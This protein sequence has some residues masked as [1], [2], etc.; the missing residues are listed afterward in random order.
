MALLGIPSQ[1]R[2]FE[3]RTRAITDVATMLYHQSSN[4]DA[5]VVTLIQ[6]M[7][8]EDVS[9]AL[10][11]QDYAWALMGIAATFRGVFPRDLLL[12]MGRADGL[13]APLRVLRFLTLHR[14]LQSGDDGRNLWVSETLRDYIYRLQA[15]DDLVRRHRRAALFYQTQDRPLTYAW[16]LYLAGSY[17]EAARVVLASAEDLLDALYV[18][19]LAALLMRFDA[20]QVPDSWFAL[21][22][23]LADLYR[24]KG[25]R[26][27][28]IVACQRAIKA[29]KQPLEKASV[30][31]R[32]G[33][34]HEDHNML[35]ALE[36]YNQAL[37]N[38]P[39]DAEEVTDT[40]KDRAWVN[41][42]LSSLDAKRRALYW[43]AAMQDLTRALAR[44]ADG[45]WSQQADIYNAFASLYRAQQRYD[46][47]V[48]YGRKALFL[49]MEHG[50]LQA[51]A[52]SWSNLAVTYTEM[53]DYPAAM[54]A[55]SEALKTFKQLDHQEAI[56][57]VY[58]N[59]GV[60]LYFQDKVSEAV[61][62]YKQSL[63]IF[64]KL[65][66]PYA[67]AQ[68]CYN[69]AESLAALDDLELSQAYWRRGYEL[70]LRSGL[71]GEAASFLDLCHNTPGL[72]CDDVVGALPPSPEPPVDDRL[73]DVHRQ[74]LDIV[75]AEGEV[76][77]KRLVEEAGISASTAKR[78]LSDLVDWDLLER[79][80]RGAGSHYVA[81]S[82]G[83][84][85]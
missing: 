16:H 35:V 26:D 80:G 3:L 56:A 24:Q 69:L 39:E 76:T 79:R 9:Q 68:A 44:V 67:Q 73:S 52:K 25:E 15:S 14:Y 50:D 70:S 37:D 17:A 6:Y 19:D 59:M 41:I 40:F 64:E 11:T 42:H 57:T 12:D 62:Y 5:N 32:L 4:P 29:A 49:R 47:A 81:P 8:C 46:V 55:L 58:L 43:D 36:Y 13:I 65:G 77:R 22:R 2:F 66:I 54:M 61:G 28:A 51:V 27:L 45:A 74:A 75:R 30:Y 7:A 23:L 18:D 85:R 1:S 83:A 71:D 72:V 31:R 33:K 48:T 20:S 60:N 84:T 38:F 63:G 82:P 78:R 34:L 53:Q 21:Q 10:H